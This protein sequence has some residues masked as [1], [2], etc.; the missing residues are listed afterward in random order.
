MPASRIQELLDI[1]HKIEEGAPWPHR[2]LE[3][4]VISFD[5]KNGQQGVNGFCPNVPLY[6]TYRLGAG[7]RARAMRK[8]LSAALQCDAYGFLPGREAM[9]FWLG[10]QADRV[11]LST[12]PAAMW[13]QHAEHR[14]C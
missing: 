1:F 6:M 8:A 4:H 2:R 5:K 12:R 14:H 11:G 10:I 13:A 7:L 3:G 9:E